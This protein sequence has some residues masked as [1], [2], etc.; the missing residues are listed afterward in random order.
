MLILS[1]IDIPE[2]YI[3]QLLISE[4]HII[5]YGLMYN[6]KLQDILTECRSIFHSHPI[7]HFP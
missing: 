3:I 5:I 6:I 2:K 4:A 1:E 7:A